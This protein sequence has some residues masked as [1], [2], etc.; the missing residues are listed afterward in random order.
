MDKGS[1]EKK[2]IINISLKCEIKKTSP[3][4]AS[5]AK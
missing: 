3:P 4:M 5:G 1:S 2:T